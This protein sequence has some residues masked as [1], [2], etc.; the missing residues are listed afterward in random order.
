MLLYNIHRTIFLLHRTADVPSGV[1]TNEQL[2]L[3]ISYFTKSQRNVTHTAFHE[4]KRSEP[5]NILKN[6]VRLTLILINAYI[7]KYIKRITKQFLI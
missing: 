4:Q 7:C 5:I 2:F 3:K 1:I 6:E